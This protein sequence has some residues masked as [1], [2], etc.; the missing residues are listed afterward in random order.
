MSYNEEN[1][2][3]ITQ[4]ERKMFNQLRENESDTISLAKKISESNSCRPR[5]IHEYETSLSRGM[6]LADAYLAYCWKY[7][8]NLNRKNK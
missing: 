8:F 1:I 6:Q 4:V 3:T 5:L 2:L 7:R